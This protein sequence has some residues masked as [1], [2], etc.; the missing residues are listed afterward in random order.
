[1]GELLRRRRGGDGGGRPEAELRRRCEARLAAL[2]LPRPFSE[3]A[4]CQ[5]L[6]AQ[7]GRPLVLYPAEARHFA[8]GVHG[9]LVS[10]PAGDVIVYNQEETPFHRRHTIIHEACHLIWGHLPVE[11]GSAETLALLFPDLP[12]EA[13]RG[14]LRR[15][16][17]ASSED[18]READMLASLILERAE[19]GADD[20]TPPP[21]P[22]SARLLAM[23]GVTPEDAT[24]APANGSARGA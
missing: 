9:C 20:A 1:M 3:T 2:P 6:A 13:V 24:E 5:A 22:T 10:F 17:Y 19:D 16:R 11:Q 18:E 4:F 8:P 21:N 7:R 23:L 14:V 12:D 15:T